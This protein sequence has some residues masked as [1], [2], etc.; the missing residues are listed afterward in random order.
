MSLLT[1]L[2]SE[3]IPPF[4]DYNPRRYL[5]LSHRLAW[6]G[7]FFCSL[8]C[9]YQAIFGGDAHFMWES[10]AGLTFFLWAILLIRTGFSLVGRLV[11]S[12][13]FLPLAILF[14]LVSQ[15]VQFIDYLLF[16][17]LVSVYAN[18]PLVVFSVRREP[19]IIFAAMAINLS[20]AL[21]AH[22]IFI[23]RSYAPVTELIQNYMAT[24]ILVQFFVVGSIGAILYFF[25]FVID[26]QQARHMHILSELQSRKEK[27]KAYSDSH[28]RLSKFQS[29]TSG[30]WEETLR[31]ITRE[32]TEQLEVSQCG[33]WRFS[34][35]ESTLT[36]LMVYDKSNSFYHKDTILNSSLAPEYF[37]AI[38]T[39]R[40]IAAEDAETHPSTKEFKDFYLQPLS[41]KS[42]LDIPF[43]IDGRF[44]GVICCEHK[45]V[46]RPWT[47]E[48]KMYLQ[49]VS[50][51][52]SMAYKSLKRREAEDYIRQQNEEIRLI[53][54][55]LEA[56]VKDRTRLL[57]DKNQ[58]LLNYAFLNAHMLRAPVSRIM[59][60]LNLLRIIE[61]D[62]ERREVMERLD[63]AILDLDQVVRAIQKTLE[64]GE[65]LDALLYEQE[66]SELGT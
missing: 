27:L 38:R 47:D 49:A 12:A 61:E 55:S 36:S 37:R 13:L 25:N 35:E 19:Q 14:V 50:E 54:E 33:I 16:G 31:S 29:V 63:T 22:P 20:T 23:N 42:L 10:I 39:E 45:Y 65:S 48:D 3:R 1:N 58:Q 15:E 43:Y 60:I 62:T 26:Q 30:L 51:I 28:V 53:N 56:R 59:G 64:E 32:I 44:S 24:A 4:R 40:I 9:G 5:V 66:N 8:V 34:D 57:M 18:C 11:L 17:L 6:G 7:A 2:F 41:I 21:I 46:T 52:L